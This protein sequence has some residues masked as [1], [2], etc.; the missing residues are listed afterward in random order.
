M[1]KLESYS[2]LTK[3]QEDLLKKG[4]CFGQ[5]AALAVYTKH[6]SGLNTKTSLKQVKSTTDVPNITGTTYFKFTDPRFALKQEFQTSLLYKTI[7]EF[8]PEKFKNVKGKIEVEA[9]RATG[10][11]KQTASVECSSDKTKSKVAIGSDHLFKTSIV[12]SF[13]SF[14]AGID[15]AFD[16]N[17]WRFGTY[18]A[19]AYYF[20]DKYRAV[21]KHISTDNKA[22]TFGN[23]VGSFYFVQT[24]QTKFGAAA[25]VSSAGLSD[26]TVGF[27][28]ALSDNKTL[29]GRISKNGTVGWN[30]RAKVNQYVSVTTANQFNLKSFCSSEN[31]NWQLGLRVK[32]NQ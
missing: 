29:K 6:E 31:P 21:L 26:L 11:C 13:G 3:L 19:A 7:L 15:F 18:N 1:A 10:A 32:I 4:Y 27:Q 28:H 17:T 12:R 22:Y 8:T 25:T 9:N 14:G 23:L 20:A 24:A 5:L 2:N 16:L 30:L